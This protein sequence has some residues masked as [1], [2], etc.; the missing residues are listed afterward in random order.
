MEFLPIIT[1]EELQELSLNEELLTIFS[2]DSKTALKIINTVSTKLL[3]Q[4]DKEI[5]YDKETEDYIFPTDLKVACVC[6]CESYY[7]YYVKEWMNNSS[8]KI[9][10]ER[11]DDYS[12]TYSDKDS[13]YNFFWI[14]TDKKTLD[15]IDTYS[16]IIWMGRR[17][18]HTR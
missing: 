18:V 13:E 12:Y 3:S 2:S 4:I 1:V 14:P 15:L 8:K 16:W 6:L 10:S 5:F 17:E 9:I 11:I 7:S